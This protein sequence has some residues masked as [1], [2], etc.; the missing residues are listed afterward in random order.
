M[1]RLVIDT[2]NIL[3]RV[4]AASSKHHTG[5]PPEEMAGLA[6]HMS[7]SVMN[8]YVKKYRPDEIAVTFEGGN[9]WR[10]EYTK[11][12]QCKSGHVYKANRVKDDS[13]APLFELLK[14]FEELVRNYT[15]IVCLSNPRL[16]GDDVFA[17]YVQRFTS[18]GDEVIGLSGDKDFV[19]LLKNPHFTLVN[20]DDGQPRTV[21]DVCGVDDPLFFMFE[22]G[23][24][25]DRGDNVFSAYPRVQKK[26]LLKAFTDEYELAKLMNESWTFTDEETG[27]VKEHRVG[28]LFEENVLLMD[29]ESQPDDIRKIIDETIDSALANRGKFSN[30]KFIGF[31][32]KHGLQKIIDSAPQFMGL[33]AKPA[34]T[35]AQNSSALE[36]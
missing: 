22:K 33:L 4:F 35:D 10:K 30:F 8:K 26:R 32:G 12:S 25:G 5:T 9:N 14:S 28:D 2:N 19:Q 24:R 36:F 29:L 20:P 7:L 16:E 31:C 34:T 3:F 11:S 1:R 15:T 18:I 6:L 27:V 17:G 23:I 13:M 21:V